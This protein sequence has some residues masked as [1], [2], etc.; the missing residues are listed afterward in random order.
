FGGSLRQDWGSVK[1]TQ[2]WHSS[3]LPD[4]SYGGNPGGFVVS[5]SNGTFWYSGD[6]S[7]SYDFKLI[8]EEYKLDLCLLPIG[9]TFTMG[10]RDAARCAEFAGAK[11]VVGLHYDSFPPI[12]I[13]HDAAVKAFQEKSAELFLLA[14]GEEREF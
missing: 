5:T 11:R 7:L 14:I 2:A 10:F 6:T 3:S 4:G 13:D 8:G 9:D 12:E 1:F